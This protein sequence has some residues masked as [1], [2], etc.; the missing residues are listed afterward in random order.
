MV[1][2]GEFIGEEIMFEKTPSGQPE[3]SRKESAYSEGD[4]YLVECLCDEW[5]KTKEIFAMMS[6]KKDFMNVENLLKRSY[7]QKKVWRQYK[8][9]LTGLHYTINQQQQ[10]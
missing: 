6:L 7:Q 4:T 5:K 3:P 9:K 2:M 1:K 8:A 10:E